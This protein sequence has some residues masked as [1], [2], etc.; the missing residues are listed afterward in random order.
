[1]RGTGEI[2]NT[3]HA[4]RH[5]QHLPYGE[6][7]LFSRFTFENGQRINAR[8]VMDDRLPPLKPKPLL[9]RRRQ[10]PFLREKILLEYIRRASTNLRDVGDS[11]NHQA[12]EMK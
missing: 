5:V 9:H 6:Y 1:M 10:K 2:K 7:R 4:V 3:H 11:K 8:E 12:I